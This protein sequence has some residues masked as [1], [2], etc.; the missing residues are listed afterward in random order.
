M[1][2]AFDFLRARGYTGQTTLALPTDPCTFGTYHRRS[3]EV[4][5]WP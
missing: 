2:S 5:T 3:A 4:L 1:D